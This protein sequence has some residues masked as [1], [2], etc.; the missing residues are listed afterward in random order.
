[1]PEENSTG[2][3]NLKLKELKELKDQTKTVSITFQC[4]SWIED[5]IADLSEKLDT[6]RSE[7]IRLILESYLKEIVVND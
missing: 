7:T 4:P 6:K 2:K 1:M 5:E 3:T